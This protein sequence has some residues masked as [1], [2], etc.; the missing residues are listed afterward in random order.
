MI[1]SVLFLSD[2]FQS[3]SFG[4]PLVFFP[5]EALGLEDSHIPTFW[6]IVLQPL[7]SNY[8]DSLTDE[9]TLQRVYGPYTTP[10]LW[11]NLVLI[12]IRSE[13]LRSQNPIFSGHVHLQG[14]GVPA[15]SSRFGAAGR[16]GPKDAALHEGPC[17][18]MVL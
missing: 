18:P 11:V 6:L 2:F 7:T 17:M 8:L 9:I 15:L 10:V 4:T 3:M 16:S 13:V 14:L 1:L 5:V 12:Y